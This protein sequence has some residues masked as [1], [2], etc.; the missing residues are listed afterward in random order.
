ME[1]GREEN[2]E[3]VFVQLPFS[4]VQWGNLYCCR[5]PCN[6]SVQPNHAAGVC[7]CAWHIGVGS[8]DACLLT[9]LLSLLPSRKSWTSAWLVL[10]GN[11]L[12]FYKDPKVAAGWVSGAGRRHYGR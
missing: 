11:S 6:K 5:A 3:N 4:E 7:G 9:L 10:A 1:A 2:V 8:L 12:M